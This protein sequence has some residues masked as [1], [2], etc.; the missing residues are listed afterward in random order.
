M[1]SGSGSAVFGLFE[2]AGGGRRGRG[3]AGG[4]PR[5][6]G[7]AHDRPPAGSSRTRSTGSVSS[8]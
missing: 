7:L 4:A 8:R 3:A 5:L 1:M 2:G 6:A